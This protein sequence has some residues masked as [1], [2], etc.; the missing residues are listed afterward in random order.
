MREHNE[1]RLERL[2]RHRFEKSAFD[3]AILVTGATEI[4][5]STCPW[6]RILCSVCCG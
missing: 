4:T 2:N 3:K 1:F 6:A 5:R